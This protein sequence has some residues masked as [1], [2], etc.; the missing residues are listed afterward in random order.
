MSNSSC[1]KIK[2]LYLLKILLENTDENHKLTV[3]EI[4]EKLLEYNI[5]AERK[6][7]Y[8]DIKLL[9]DWGLDVACDKG[10]ANKYFVASRKFKLSELRLIIDAVRTYEHISS[11]Q[12]VEIINKVKGLTSIYES[13]KL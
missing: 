10:R 2:T 1:A 13:E 8:S 6:S 9:V 3:N 4:I 12:R 11:E 5:T 7:I